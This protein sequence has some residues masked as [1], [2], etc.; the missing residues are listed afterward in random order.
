MTHTIFSLD[1]EFTTLGCVGNFGY[2]SVTKQKLRNQS[3]AILSRYKL[4]I[5]ICELKVHS[6][7]SSY[8]ISIF[9]ENF[10]DSIIRNQCFYV[11]NWF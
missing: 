5:K 2:F 7:V 3:L 10:N 8:S 1:I 9:L 4:Y 11:Y 6:I